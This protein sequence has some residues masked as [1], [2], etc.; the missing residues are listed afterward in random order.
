[1][2]WM[3]QWENCFQ[4][5]SANR[6]SIS[7]WYPHYIPLHPIFLSHG[8]KGIFLI[9]M[10]MKNMFL[11][12]T[13]TIPSIYPIIH[14]SNIPLSINISH[15]PF[16]IVIDPIGKAIEDL[17]DFTAIFHRF[18]TACSSS[19]SCDRW[20]GHN[21][22]TW[23]RPTRLTRLPTRSRACNGTLGETPCGKIIGSLGL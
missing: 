3:N 14:Y 5:T 18:S 1:M 23:R 19:V 4:I 17:M 2:N 9:A 16:I 6:R 10:N 7:H 8:L 22:V 15:D 13:N 20:S 21:L 11:K 12:T